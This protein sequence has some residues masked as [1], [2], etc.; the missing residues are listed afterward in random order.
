MSR[1]WGHS[2]E[3]PKMAKSSS[4]LTPFHA[5][6]SND[7]RAAVNTLPAIGAGSDCASETEIQLVQGLGRGDSRED[8]LCKSL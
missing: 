2:E 4:P 5:I 7:S 8:Y 6:K 3:P 1:T